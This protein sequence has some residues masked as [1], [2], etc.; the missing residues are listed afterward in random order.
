[1]DLKLMNKTSLNHIKKSKTNGE[2]KIKKDEGVSEFG[3][4]PIVLGILRDMSY[5]VV[6]WD[7]VKALALEEGSK[8]LGL[9]KF[10][11]L[12]PGLGIEVDHEAAE[13]GLAVVI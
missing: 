9:G 3:V 7:F 4:G 5:R 1:M 6:C 10:D 8:L 13:E 11:E 12:H 2:L